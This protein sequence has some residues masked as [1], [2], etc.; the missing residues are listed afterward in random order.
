MDTLL[1]KADEDANVEA[2]RFPISQHPA[3]G[4]GPADSFI[5]H[6]C[7][8]GAIPAVCCANAGLSNCDSHGLVFGIKGFEPLQDV[9]P[10]Q[11]A[12][13]LDIAPR[14]LQD[15]VEGIGG[16]RNARFA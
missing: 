7:I 6:K 8:L 2:A 5:R 16:L 15:F 14:D 4:S 10:T 3:G 1:T 13:G 12:H 9:L 11:G